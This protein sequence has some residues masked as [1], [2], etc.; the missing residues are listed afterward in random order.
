MSPPKCAE[1]E[2]VARHAI[3]DMLTAL[4]RQTLDARPSS[5]LTL[6]RWL[7]DLIVAHQF[8]SLVYCCLVG[9]TC[10]AAHIVVSH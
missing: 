5:S 6:V 7:V 10:F 9:M 4:A 8:T 3:P 2:F 1:E